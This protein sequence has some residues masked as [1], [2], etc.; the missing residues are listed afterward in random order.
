MAQKK[1]LFLLSM[2]KTAVLVYIFGETM[3][4]I[5]KQKSYC[6]RNLQE[7]RVFYLTTGG[8]SFLEQWWDILTTYES[9]VPPAGS[10]VVLGV[11][12]SDTKTQKAKS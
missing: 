1:N 5:K 8:I 4:H 2:L 11:K 6:V 10:L 3:V 9:S 12:S 7:F